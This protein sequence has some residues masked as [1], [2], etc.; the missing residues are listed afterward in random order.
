M[1]PCPLRSRKWCSQAPP[2]SSCTRTGARRPPAIDN[3]LTVAD[4]FDVQVMIHTDTLNE[5][6]FVEDTGRRLQG[7][8]HPRLPT[9]RARAAGTPP[10]SSRSR[11]LPTSSRPRPIRRGPTRS[12]PSPSISTCLWCATISTP[13]FPKTWRSPKAASAR[14]PSRPRDILHDMGAFS[15]ISSDSQA[16]GRVG[17]VLIRTW[18]TA[19]K[20]KTPARG[21]FSEESGDNDNAR[22]KRYIAKYTHQSGHRARHEPAHRLGRGGQARRSGS[23]EPRLL[24]GEARACAARRLH[25]RGADGRPQRLDP[26]AATD[27]LPADVRRLRQAQ[28][29]FVGHFRQPGGTRGRRA[30]ERLGVAKQMLAVENTRGRHRQGRR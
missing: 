9:R 25:R 22:V 17:E 8:H 7:P 16:M 10:T 2:A 21:A 28:N 3:C 11:A 19:D 30:R 27:A 15:I 6:G 24:R 13:P 4:A 23:V 1:P 29:E 26:D 18:Q 14:K 20:M 12:T 5:S